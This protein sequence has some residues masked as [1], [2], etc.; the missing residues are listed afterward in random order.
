MRR[1]R[2]GFRFLLRPVFGIGIVFATCIVGMAAIFGEN[3]LDDAR[4]GEGMFEVPYPDNCAMFET[5]GHATP[6]TGRIAKVDKAG[7]K[8]VL[9]TGETIVRDDI[10]ISASHLVF[11]DGRETLDRNDELVFDVFEPMNGRCV[12]VSYPIS[13]FQAFADDPANPRCAH[14]D[15]ALFRLDGHVRRYRPLELAP[16]ELVADFRSGRKKGVKIGFAN[17]PSVNDGQYWSIVEAAAFPVE[18]HDP[19][20]RNAAL[21]AHDGDAWSGDSGAAIR[22]D[23]KLVGIHLRGFDSEYSAYAPWRANIGTLLGSELRMRISDFL[24]GADPQ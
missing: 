16:A 19:S 10:V 8:T 4:L 15:V 1:L 5:L 9:G 2:A 18:R 12:V 7:M 3:N 22:I 24:A 23:G 11:R 20:C 14:L 13:G 6:S 17:H 21:F